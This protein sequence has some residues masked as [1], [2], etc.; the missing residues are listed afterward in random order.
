MQSGIYDKF[1]SAL[2]AKVKEFKMGDPLAEG[3]TIGP[4]VNEA[5]VSKTM[6]HIEDAVSKGAKVA[7]GGKRG[8]GEGLFVEPT[9]L[10]DVP[11]NADISVEETFGPLAALFKFETEEEVI[12]RANNVPVGLAAYF[13]TKDISRVTRVSEALEVGMIGCN[14][15]LISQPCIPFGG[16]KESGFGR[17]GGKDGI[18][19][20]MVEKVS[21]PKP[22]NAIYQST[23]D[24]RFPD[25]LHVDANFDICFFLQIV[26]LGI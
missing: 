16:V 20:Y 19:E 23:N 6:R 18:N 15:G 11:A 12:E 4:L 25:V 13:Y 2:V 17:E 7:Q 24:I 1:A 14:T 3:T 9:V 8:E 5:G 21:D 10:V 26:S 22:V